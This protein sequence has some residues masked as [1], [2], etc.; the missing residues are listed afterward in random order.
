MFLWKSV[1]KIPRE[2]VKYKNRKIGRV[3]TRPIN[4]YSEAFPVGI[5]VKVI[6]V[7]EFLENSAAYF[8]L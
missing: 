7:S 3:F 8:R 4:I 5:R 6:S 2:L 1:L